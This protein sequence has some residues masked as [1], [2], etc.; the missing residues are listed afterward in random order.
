M[1]VIAKLLLPFSATMAS[2]ATA[3]NVEIRKLFPG[4]NLLIS[5]AL[6]IQMYVTSAWSLVIQEFPEDHIPKIFKSRF[7]FFLGRNP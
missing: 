6:A 5:D 1:L 7:M 2:S 3:F 4:I